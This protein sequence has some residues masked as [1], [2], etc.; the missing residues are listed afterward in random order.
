M[1]FSAAIGRFL[2]RLERN[3]VNMHG[4]MV[5]NH[6]ETVAKGFWAP[7]TEDSPHRMF[8]IGKSITS[9]MIGI[10]YG[11]GKLKLKDKIADYFTDMRPET[12]PDEIASMTI[13]DML[14]MATC[15]KLTTYSRV[16]CND[17]TSTFFSALPTNAS[18][19]VFSYDTSATHT[20]SALI[21]R[22]SGMSLLSFFKERIYTPL[23]LT[24]EIRWL[25]DP[26]GVCQGGSGLVMTLPDLMKVAACVMLGGDGIIAAD[27]IKMATSK[28]IETFL[29]PNREERYGYGYQFW[30]TRENGVAMYGMGG[31]YV[32]MLP[33]KDVI[34][35]CMADTQL[36]AMGTQDILD[37]FFEEILPHIG[38]ERDSA[39]AGRLAALSVKPFQSIKALERYPERGYVFH[40]GNPFDFERVWLQSGLFVFQRA[41]ER[42]SIPF[43]LGDMMQTVFPGTCEPALVTAAFFQSGGFALQMNLIGDTP[44]GF[45]MQCVFDESAMTIQMR[46]VREALVEK[47]DGVATGKAFD[48]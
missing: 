24:G 8:S 1:A 36:Q 7:F 9:L 32:I 20:L 15:H 37:A 30:L 11:E 45:I 31:Q 42:L 44:C 13:E 16:K 10:L 40:A 48:L 4:F 6:G 38:E 34:F 19:A 39:L 29:L 22:L 25:T 17:W 35:G 12:L 26:V 21:E 43:R 33:E 28:Q 47:F 14:K 27:Y 46:G 41:G 18:G 3:G 23:G 5:L 2:D